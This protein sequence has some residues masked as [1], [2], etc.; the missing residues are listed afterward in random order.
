MTTTR[1]AHVIGAGVAGLSAATI[2]A[3][4]GAKVCL[5]DSAPQAG[6][7]CRSYFDPAMDAVID[8]GNHFVLTGNR[9]VFA[10]LNRIGA[11]VMRWLATAPCRVF[12]RH[13][14]RRALEDSPQPGAYSG[15]AVGFGA[16][17]ARNPDRRI[18]GAGQIVV[19]P[20]GSDH[21]RGAVL[22]RAFAGKICCRPFFLGALN[23]QPEE[24]SAALA[25]QLL[26]KTFLRQRR[27][28]LSHPDRR[29]D[30]GVGIRRS[31]SGFPAAQRRC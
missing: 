17:G 4:K 28:C 21:R 13:R 7:R 26:R 27:Q 30:P 3:S 15:L 6:G 23:T 16:Q 19:G 11:A 2:L 14:Q 20:S 8:N 29:S 22:R 25:A 31:G 5:Y 18:S 12:F 9:A 1:T 24:A 10:Y